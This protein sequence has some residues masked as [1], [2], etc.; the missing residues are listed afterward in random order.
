M[1]IAWITEVRNCSTSATLR[2]CAMDDGRHPELN[3][4]TYYKD[5]WMLVSPTANSSS[6]R[7]IKP[8][9]LAVPWSYGGK[10]RLVMRVSCDG[11]EKTLS[12]E[13]RGENGWDYLVIRDEALNIITQTEIGS[14]GDAPG[15]NHSHWALVLHEDGKLEWHLFERQGLRRDDLLNIVGSVG[16]FYLDLFIKVRDSLPELISIAATL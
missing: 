15:V 14:L 5:D 9:N 2:I 7:T 10:Q 16:N 4:V 13:V 3:N 8:S 1:A 6:P 12:A 11:I